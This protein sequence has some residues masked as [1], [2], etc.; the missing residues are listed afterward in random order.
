MMRISVYFMLPSIAVS[1]IPTTKPVVRNF[2]YQG[3]VPPVG[4]F[5]PGIFSSNASDNTIKYLREAELRGDLAIDALSKMSLEEQSPYWLG[6][7]LYEFARMGAGWRN[8]FVETSAYFKLEENYQPGNVLKMNAENI[9][10][11]KYNVELS[12]GRLAM[13]ACLGYMAEEYVTRVPIF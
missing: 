13:L 5:D 2:N 11:R 6:V 10:D 1:F 12:N 3:D 8:P 4:Y 7:A 9:T